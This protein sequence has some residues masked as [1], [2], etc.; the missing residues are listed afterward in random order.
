MNASNDASNSQLFLTRALE[1][2]IRIVVL[3]LL[4]VWCFKIAR[5]FIE[6]IVWGVIIAV[7]IHPLH[8]RLASAFGGRGGLAA[9]LITLLVLAILI[10]PTIMLGASLVETA[11]NLS[12]EFKEGTLS[13]PP[14]PE[15]VKSW[16][17]MGEHLYKFWD[18]A[19]NNLEAALSKITP[20][21]KA[22]GGWLLSTAAGTGAGILKFVIAVIISGAL[23]AHSHGSGQFARAIATRLAGDR[24]ED[25]W[26][27]RGRQ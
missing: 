17:V 12:T 13:V 11:H 14:P 8:F 5:P 10:V 19:S 2:T 25:Q 7:A 27:W 24:G 3:G 6:P 26:I 16:P 15:G 21:I 4:L 9:T 22:V 18:L 23:L 1:A 20:Q